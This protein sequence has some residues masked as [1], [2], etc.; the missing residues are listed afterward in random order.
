M[1]LVGGK[2]GS[3]GKLAPSRFLLAILL[4]LR[5]LGDLFRI[6][7]QATNA[8]L[9]SSPAKGFCSLMNYAGRVSRSRDGGKGCKL[10]RNLFGVCAH[11]L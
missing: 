5:G 3:V 11:Q 10:F 1:P 7:L 2:G 6:L 9:M 4:V 8:F